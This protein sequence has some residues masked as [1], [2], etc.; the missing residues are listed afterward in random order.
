MK[1]QQ[2]QQCAAM[3]S[4]RNEMKQIRESLSQLQESVKKMEIA[5]SRNK[6][7]NERHEESRPETQ[8]ES[9]RDQN[10]ED[11]PRW[12]DRSYGNWRQNNQY[13][14]RYRHMPPPMVNRFLYV[15]IRHAYLTCRKTNFA[16]RIGN[17][18]R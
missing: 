11:A 8:K 2:Q 14:T 9:W 13:N 12:Q 15:Y 3:H 1:Q 10:N 4:E 5:N 17:Y 16:S 7:N 6:T 18:L